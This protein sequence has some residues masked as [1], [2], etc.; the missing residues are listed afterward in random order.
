[1]VA[2]KR[3]NRVEIFECSDSFSSA[4]R[5]YDNTLYNFPCY[6]CSYLL[7]YLLNAIHTFTLAPILVQCSDV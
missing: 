1:M 3:N 5:F 2:N 4:L 7:A 6:T